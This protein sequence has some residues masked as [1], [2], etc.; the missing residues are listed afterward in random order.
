MNKMAGKDSS[1]DTDRSSTISEKTKTQL[2]KKLFRAESCIDKTRPPLEIAKEEQIDA[3]GSDVKKSKIVSKDVVNS[4]RLDKIEK[5]L[6]SYVSEGTLN[7]RV[8]NR[9]LE[10]TRIIPDVEDIS[11]GGPFFVARVIIVS[12]GKATLQILNKPVWTTNVIAEDGQ[13][14]LLE[15]IKAVCNCFCM[16]FRMCHGI[17]PDKFMACSKNIHINIKNKTEKE[18]PFLRVTSTKCKVWFKVG[19][20]S[21]HQNQCSDCQELMRYVRKME[22]KNASGQEKL[23]ERLNG[24]SNFKISKLTPR[25]R[26]IRLQQSRTSK[27]GLRKK[28]EDLLENT[29]DMKIGLDDQQNAELEKIVNYIGQNQANELET[30]FL[31]GQQHGPEFTEFMRETWRR[32][33]EDRKQFLQDQIQNGQRQTKYGNRWSMITYRIGMLTL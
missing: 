30:V 25:S 11:K 7:V 19:R 29:K 23:S 32:D 10:V 17:S 20:T 12:S 33:V 16:E 6:N 4:E 24:S 13:T 3:N 1:R 18:I 14:V 27:A 21:K 8:I 5:A 22:H 2:L 31:E 26:Q 9:C 28:V 15:E